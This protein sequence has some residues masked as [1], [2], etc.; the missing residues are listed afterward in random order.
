[1]KS[2]TYLICLLAVSTVINLSGC[3]TGTQTSASATSAAPPEVP[4]LKVVIDCGACKV[5]DNVP[6]LIGAGYKEAA[7]GSGVQVAATPEAIV[8]IKEYAARSDGARFFA[9]AFAGKD[10]IRADVAY[11]EKKFTVTDYYRNAWLGIESLA[12][13]IGGMIFEKMQ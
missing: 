7:A 3:A 1:M 10:L 13:K 11:Q 5:R 9:G 4:G 6:A 12:K 2:H 8:T